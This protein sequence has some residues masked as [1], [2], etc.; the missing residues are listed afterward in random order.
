LQQEYIIWN[1]QLMYDTQV[2]KDALNMQLIG[3]TPLQVANIKF[4]DL[5]CKEGII[6]NEVYSYLMDW[7]L[8]WYI[9]AMTSLSNS[10]NGI[11][12]HDIKNL[13]HPIEKKNGYPN[14]R[15]DKILPICPS[16]DGRWKLTFR[17]KKRILMENISGYSF[18]LDEVKTIRHSLLQNMLDDNGNGIDAENFKL[19]KESGVL[20]DL[21]K[22]IIYGIF[23]VGKDPTI[24]KNNIEQPFGYIRTKHIS[25][26]KK[27]HNTIT[28]NGLN[29]KEKDVRDIHGEGF[30][31]VELTLVTACLSLSVIS[32]AASTIFLRSEFQIP[33]I[34]LT[35]VGLMAFFSAYGAL[36]TLACFCTGT[37]SAFGCNEI[38]SLL[39]RPSIYKPYC[40]IGWTILCW[41]ALSLLIGRMI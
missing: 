12:S 27:T 19:L 4:V 24:Y 40:L 31:K 9:M 22:I 7:H 41:L 16:S 34:L 37:S 20:P 21:R 28:N 13:N 38:I 30:F 1:S 18:S 33:P 3:K 32:T 6:L 36:W 8:K 14:G 25:E 23:L 39:K 26:P 29:R 11:L 2:L 17:E 35:I 5:N 10:G 15:T